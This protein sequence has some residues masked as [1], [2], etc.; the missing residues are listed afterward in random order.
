MRSAW[1]SVS[2]RARCRL[3]PPL[4][5]TSWVL[6]AI[7]LDV[8]REAVDGQRGFL[9]GFRDGRM[10][11]DAGADLP[12]GRLQQLGQRRLR[13]QLGGVWP[14]DEHPEEVSRL[15]VADDLDEAFRL[16]QDDGLRVADQ[17]E[18]AH[19]DLDALVARLLLGQ[20]QARHLGVAI[21]R[22]GHAIVV[23][24]RGILAGDDLHDVLAL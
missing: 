7:V 6:V 19:L 5:S 13:D 15:F 9:D 3:C 22:P 16:A 23:E 2:P 20:A 8:D 21:G 12:G 1:S 4:A 10:R 17:G 14:E 18:L 24:W 11:M